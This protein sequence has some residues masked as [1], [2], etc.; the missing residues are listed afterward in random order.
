MNRNFYYLPIC[1]QKFEI[2]ISKRIFNEGVLIRIHSF[3]Y[4]VKS[5]FLKYPLLLLHY[6]NY[7]FVVCVFVNRKKE[8][9][10][11]KFYTFLFYRN[12]LTS[13]SLPTFFPLLG[14]Q[15]SNLERHKTKVR[16]NEK[17]QE[18]GRV[19]ERHWKCVKISEKD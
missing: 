2:C 12:T 10:L 9:P 17:E 16:S 3:I 5:I 8:M 11:K 14:I 1:A 6:P 7:Y 15:S 18:G 4:R 19:K 13:A